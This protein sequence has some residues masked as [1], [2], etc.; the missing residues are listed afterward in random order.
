[1][2]EGIKK[3][4][5]IINWKNLFL[6][7]CIENNA[8]NNEI[9]TKVGVTISI[10]INKSTTTS[11]FALKKI[12]ETVTIITLGR[13]TIINITMLFVININSPE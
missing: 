6:L 10:V 3:G 11:N 8:D 12:D 5:I 2:I 13:K 1:M 7:I 9:R 4:V